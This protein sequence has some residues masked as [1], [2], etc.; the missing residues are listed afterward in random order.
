MSYA[1]ES[2]PAVTW[3]QSA[4]RAKAHAI[5]ADRTNQDRTRTLC[6]KTPPPGHPWRITSTFPIG[7]I[8]IHCRQSYSARSGFD[9]DD[10]GEEPHHDQTH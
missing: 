9:I 6:G 10:A 3:V 5:Q 8:C 7:V 1:P 4:Y 2:P